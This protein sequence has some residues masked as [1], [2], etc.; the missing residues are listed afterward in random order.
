[1]RLGVRVTIYAAIYL[2][3]ARA[4]PVDENDEWA[5]LTSFASPSTSSCLDFCKPSDSCFPDTSSWNQLANK[6]T[7]P[8]DLFRSP[9]N[10]EELERLYQK[11]CVLNYTLASELY[12]Q[13]AGFTV[14]LPEF[15]LGSMGN[16][17]W[18]DVKAPYHTGWSPTWSTDQRAKLGLGARLGQTSGWSFIEATYPWQ[19]QY[20]LH[21]LCMQNPDGQ[22]EG[23]LSTSSLNLPAFT[24]TARS[25]SDVAEALKFAAA[26]NIQ[27]V[28]KNTGHSYHS[29]STAAGSLMIWTAFLPKYGTVDRAWKNSC[30]TPVSEMAGP[31]GI[32]GEVPAAALK[33][34]S[35]QPF[36][37][38]YTAAFDAGLYVVGGTNPGVGGGGGWLMG[39]G[40]SFT[41]RHLGLGI[42][43]V[44]SF[45]VVTSEG[46]LLSP[47]DECTNSDMF[48]ALRG[49][50]G[51]SFGVVTSVTYKLWNEKPIQDVNIGQ[52]GGICATL[53]ASVFPS[54]TIDSLLEIPSQHGYSNDHDFSKCG[55]L[56]A[57]ESAWTAEI[58]KTA[59]GLAAFIPFLHKPSCAQVKFAHLCGSW[60]HFIIGNAT[61][62]G[63]YQTLDP[64]FGNNALN[65]WQFRGTEAEARAAWLD[66]IDVLW[67]FPGADQLFDAF[68]HNLK[69]ALRSY[70][71]FQ[72]YR[73]R[74]GQAG[75]PAT[76]ANFSYQQSG[77][78]PGA[79]SPGQ[80]VEK[81]IKDMTGQEGALQGTEHNT[82]YFWANNVPGYNGRDST[83]CGRIFDLNNATVQAQLRSIPQLT[84]SL[85]AG[86]NYFLGGT[87]AKV[88]TDATAVAPIQR[89]GQLYV[90]FP[91]AFC[92]LVSRLF[93]ADHK[94]GSATYNHYGQYEEPNFDYVAWGSNVPRLQEIKDKYDPT[95]T[96]NAKHTFGYKPVC[97]TADLHQ[98]DKP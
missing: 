37:E 84:M 30:G 8:T 40:I 42:D 76:M 64:R 58:A 71:S 15:G 63:V 87:L 67:D 80:C 5:E 20:G 23:G 44:V 35:G 60:G 7:N 61:E 69:Y 81:A 97:T 21:G 34:G 91:Y 54:M 24:V 52:I 36:R 98:L 1:V 68:G 83:G 26:N 72:D 74:W 93:P 18:D 70:E 94:F 66:Q 78:C 10:V 57:D 86:T 27:V 48:W 59:T 45:E 79:T 3:L 92:D 96:L 14:Q 11:S 47:V 75:T 43:N 41:S 17:E 22:Y 77:V 6:L 95:H 25:A 38:I 12:P 62:P 55:E 31:F 53:P 89:V 49:G 19:R 13:D 56:P 33:I 9:E 82:G 73:L 65:I 46:H 4:A 2:A 51:G 88:P 32:D 85:L 39:G 29:G 28:V 16:Y 50:G 90:P